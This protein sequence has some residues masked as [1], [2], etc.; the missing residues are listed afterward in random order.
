MVLTRTSSP[1]ESFSVLMCSMHVLFS[2]FIFVLYEIVI[3]CVV[4]VFYAGC[5]KKTQKNKKLC[6]VFFHAWNALWCFLLYFSTHETRLGI[7]YCIFHAWNA[8]WRCCVIFSSCGTRS[9][10]IVLYFYA[11]GTRSGVIVF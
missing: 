8:L 5:L 3:A 6:V 9:G 2:Y 10:D 1:S 7:L 11:C 4:F